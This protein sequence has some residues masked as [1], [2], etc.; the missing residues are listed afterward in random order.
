M[1]IERIRYAQLALSGTPTNGKN[2][3]DINPETII[4]HIRTI[5]LSPLGFNQSVP[6]GVQKGG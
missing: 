1:I 3:T 5:N 2:T 6:G 4:M